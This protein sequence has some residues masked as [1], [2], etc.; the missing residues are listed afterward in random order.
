MLMLSK[1]S[2]RMLKLR[3]V[4]KLSMAAQVTRSESKTAKKDD[5]IT[6]KTGSCP[7][8]KKS[9]HPKLVEVPTLPMFGSMLH[10]YSGTPQL[11]DQSKLHNYHSELR[12][13]FGDFFSYG[14]PGIGDGLHGKIY[15]V[16]DPNEM[17]KV[18]RSEGATPTGFI[19]RLW[20]LKKTMKLS[21]SKMID[22]NDYGLLDRGQRWKKH[23][24]FLQTGMLCPKAA[25]GFLPGIISAADIASKAAPSKV[26]NFTKFLNT[27]AFDMFCTFMF[28]E[29]TKCSS[30]TDV[31][32][33]NEENIKFCETAIKAMEMSSD[34]LISPYENL[35]NMIGIDT[36]HFNEFHA[37]YD[38]VTQIGRRKMESFYDRYKKDELNENEK[39]CYLAGAMKRYESEQHSDA[40]SLDEIFEVCVFGLWAAVDT[41]SSVTGNNIVQLALNPSVQEKLYN[42]LKD[43]TSVTGNDYLTPDVFKRSNSPYLHAVIRETYRYSAPLP[44]VMSKSSQHDIEIH[45][46]PLPKGSVIALEHIGRDEK[47]FKDAKEFK[48]ERWFPNA[49][50]SRKGTQSEVVDNPLFRDPFGQGARRCPGSRVATNEVHALVAQLVFDYKITTP[51]KNFEEVP[52]EARPFIQPKNPILEF[53]RREHAS[54]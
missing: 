16:S 48:P 38:I 53:T 27:A 39:A 47:Y 4:R 15:S 13:R 11:K 33:E 42:E 40:I 8:S 52:F 41:T 20:P 9:G 37:T 44:T 18:V 43:A 3:Q 19:E 10:Q 35:M 46:I 17:M 22:G 54:M 51:Y 49:V 1:T 32:P 12:K 25:R 30:A 23:R 2:S 50:E 21:D 31:T 36:A 28:G 14:I 34:M 7:F 5:N 24:V 26:N 6:L 29:M 45:G